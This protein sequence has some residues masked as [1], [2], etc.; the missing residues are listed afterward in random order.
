[1]ASSNN[2][3]FEAL[4]LLERERG[5]TAD[6][7]IDKITAAIII[8]VKKNY[9]VADDNVAVE[10]DS[11]K[12]KFSVAL[13]RDIVA[14]GEL[15]NEHTQV[16]LSTAQ[17]TRKSY[18]VGDRMQ[19][20]LKTK[21]FGRIAAQ[22]AKHVIR[23]GIR[24]A[25]RNQQLSEMQSKSHEI[26]TATVTNVDPDKGIVSLDLGK[27]GEAMLP[28]NEQVPGEEYTVGQQI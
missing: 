14:D 1:M 7:L 3:F 13:V 25:E 11:E 16:E 4:S 27:G 12:G 6:Y 20:A 21:E 17:Q 26:I 2:E 9:E 19:V 15:E 23:Q 28:H 8:A 24:E 22:T 10:I 18:K 5:L